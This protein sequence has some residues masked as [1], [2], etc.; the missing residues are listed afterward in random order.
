[1][2]FAA[3][4][5]DTYQ[6]ARGAVAY[7]P[8]SLKRI[9][10]HAAVGAGVGGYAGHRA[11]EKKLT[12]EQ[13]KGKSIS[14]KK[15]VARG[16]LLGSVSGG[17][18][19]YLHHHLTPALNEGAVSSLKERIRSSGRKFP[20]VHRAVGTAAGAGLGGYAAYKGQEAA[21]KKSKKKGGDPRAAAAV[22]AAYG[23]SLGHTAGSWAR[24]GHLHRAQRSMGT[25]PTTSAA[26]PAWLKGVK[27]K[28]EAKSR[29]RAEAR[30]HHPDLG[31]DPERMKKVTTEWGDYEKHHF[32]KLS[33]PMFRELFR[34]FTGA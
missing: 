26:I 33:Q 24:F 29:Y 22:G 34:I 4:A 8:A 7:A 5:K 1:M 31:G 13:R 17:Y 20:D 27:T 25:G 6:K 30:K 10:T 15:S 11:H 28:A 32:D 21:N 16:A 2:G 18:M 9:G 12:P 19:G 14:K 23:A 3:K